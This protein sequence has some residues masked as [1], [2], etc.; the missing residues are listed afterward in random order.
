MMSLNI[1]RRSQEVILYTVCVCLFVHVYVFVCVTERERL[2]SKNNALGL[3]AVVHDMLLAVHICLKV[4]ECYGQ[5]P[6][7][8]LFRERKR[9]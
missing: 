8:A 6:A 5:T 7:C 1:P 3:C 2:H 9:R 4:F